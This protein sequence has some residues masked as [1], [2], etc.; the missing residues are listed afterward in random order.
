MKTQQ[1]FERPI[2]TIAGKIAGAMRLIQQYFDRRHLA[3]S[4]K[5]WE[6]L[7]SGKD[8]FEHRLTGDVKINLYKNSV[9]SRD[10]YNGFEKEE[11]D[12]L[13]ELLREG[14]TFVDIGANVGLFSLHAAA[15]V[16]N[17]G[18]VISFEPS[19]ET[20]KR[21]TEN[22][23]LNDFENIDARNIGLSDVA[24]QLAFHVSENGHD[25]WNSF[26][27]SDGKKLQKSIQVP[28]STLDEELQHTEKS[29]IKLVK[30]DVEGWEK[31]VLLGGKKFLTD[32]SP[33]LMVEFTDANTFSAGY[34][35]HDIYDFVENCNY[36]WHRIQNGNLVT[37]PKRLYYPYDN[38][39]A[40]KNE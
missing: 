24:G 17:S 32:F 29:R 37:E 20:F 9:L 2:Y 30:I 35:I 36:K 22:I 12:F 23:H 8:F 10:I 13:K 26:A 33:T 6:N 4:K 19:P 31:F 21:L 7:F 38:L 11:I 5:K 15:I 1:L 18:S 3:L 16:G 40:I 39:I 34:P 27:N 28:V 14:D 25:A